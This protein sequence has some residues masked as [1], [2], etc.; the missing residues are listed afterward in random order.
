M[1][2]GAIVDGS[3]H[4][5]SAPPSGTRPPEP[6]L[7]RAPH[8]YYYLQT[9]TVSTDSSYTSVCRERE[10]GIRYRGMPRPCARRHAE[11]SVPR[12]TAAHQAN[13]VLGIASLLDGMPGKEQW[14]SCSPVHDYLSSMRLLGCTYH[15]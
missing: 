11:R 2:V 9:T 6:C 8:Y 1:L 13:S 10:R 15:S 4:L 14:F 12:S 3:A 7:R 5:H